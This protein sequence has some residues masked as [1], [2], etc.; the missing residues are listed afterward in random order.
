MI[1]GLPRPPRKPEDYECC[2]RHCDPCIM[3]Y[4]HEALERWRERVAAKG[5]DPDAVLA[6]FSRGEGEG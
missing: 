1:E 6:E 4:H 5:L 2:R 3:D